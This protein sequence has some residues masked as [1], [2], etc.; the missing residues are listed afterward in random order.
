[1]TFAE[2]NFSFFDRKARKFLE[3]YHHLKFVVEQREERKADSCTCLGNAAQV[4]ADFFDNLNADQ[5]P[6]NLKAKV[7]EQIKKFKTTLNKKTDC[8]FAV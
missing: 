7:H 1:M 2:K 5:K 3:K 6:G 8:E 4:Y